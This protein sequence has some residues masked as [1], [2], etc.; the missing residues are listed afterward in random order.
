MQKEQTFLCMVYPYLRA[1]T[2]WSWTELA[3]DL[4]MPTEMRVELLKV[5]RAEPGGKDIWETEEK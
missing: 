3:N 1:V 2:L 5:L 4:S